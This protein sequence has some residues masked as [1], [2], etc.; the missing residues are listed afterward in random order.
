MVAVVH[1]WTDVTCNMGLK[2]LAQD[3]RRG[4]KEAGGTSIEFNTVAVSDG[5]TMGTEGMRS[6]MSRE[7]IA[8]LGARSTRA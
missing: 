6:L 1:C 4:I 5:I 7:V 8:D 3:V 2:D